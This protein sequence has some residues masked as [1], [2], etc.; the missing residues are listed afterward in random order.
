MEEKLS[1][2]EI[3][4]FEEDE[5]ERDEVEENEDPELGPR[6][7]MTVHYLATDNAKPSV[8]ARQAF[9]DALR[10]IARSEYEKLAR[11]GRAVGLPNP[12]KAMAAFS[13]ALESFP[14]WFEQHDLVPKPGFDT[15]IFNT[16]ALNSVVQQA[17][18]GEPF[19]LR[20]YPWAY[21]GDVPSVEIECKIAHP[22]FRPASTTATPAGEQMLTKKELRDS[23]VDLFTQ[24]L[25]RWLDLVYERAKKTGVVAKDAYT[26]ERDMK[27]LV[28][29][30]VLGYSP[31]EIVALEQ[32]A[33][34]SE[35]AALDFSRIS[36]S[37]RRAVEKS[38]AAAADRLG[39][40]VA[41]LTPGPKPGGF[42]Q[43]QRRLRGTSR[44]RG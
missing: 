7:Y 18:D 36:Q 35:L 33:E 30:Q 5:F 38:I 28:Q 14:A 1:P 9:Y 27:R 39:L 19:R 16:D 34:P 42:A 41:Q 43:E 24:R 12:A 17:A 37:T 15:S 10:D 44:S 21:K 25:D 2:P 6:I 40:D 32:G 22:M 31:A 8:E 3:D 20:A 23:V 4:R 11:V 26:L 29:K 13:H